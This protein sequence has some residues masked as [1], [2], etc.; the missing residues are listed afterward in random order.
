MAAS[1]PNVVHAKPAIIIII[2]VRQSLL[3]I[4]SLL[5]KAQDFF[6]I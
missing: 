1:L 4:S 5:E 3:F 2:N 6:K